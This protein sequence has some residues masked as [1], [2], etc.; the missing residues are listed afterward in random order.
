M[1]PLEQ[2]LAALRDAGGR[3]EHRDGL[4][5]THL[6]ERVDLSDGVL[7]DRLMRLERGGMIVR[8]VRGKR[9]FTIELT[10]KGR[11]AVTGLPATTP[12]RTPPA[13]E[14]RAVVTAIQPKPPRPVVVPPPP[15][16][17]QETPPVEQPAAE[18]VLRAVAFLTDR[19]YEQVVAQALTDYA[20]RAW[21]SEYVR[22][23]LAVRTRRVDAY[24]E[25]TE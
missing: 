23:A 5:F 19:S 18:L 8:D 9:T 25:A 6:R 24:L 15:E 16:P 1:T 7:K 12:A 13:D 22:D 14:P 2:V 21:S 4:C 20:D 3:V 17:E 10:E 11:A